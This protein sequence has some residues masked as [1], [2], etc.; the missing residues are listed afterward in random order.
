MARY[1]VL[2]VQ[3]LQLQ[4]RSL[5]QQNVF[6]HVHLDVVHNKLIPPNPLAMK[7]VDHVLK[8]F[9]NQSGVDFLFC[10]ECAATQYTSS[11]AA[12]W[13][14]TCTYPQQSYFQFWHDSSGEYH[15]C[16]AICLGLSVKTVVIVLAVFVGF[17]VIVFVFF[18]PVPEHDQ[19]SS[20]DK[21]NSSTVIV[22]YQKRVKTIVLTTMLLLLLPTTTLLLIK[23]G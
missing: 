20:S 9:T 13:Y 12:V 1:H 14:E 23:K 15:P 10:T 18:V 4:M 2:L 7:L 11:I 17:M 3:T 6:L 22:K 21:E 5:Q 8:D 16:K 19:H